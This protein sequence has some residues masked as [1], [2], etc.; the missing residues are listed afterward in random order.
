MRHTANT[1]SSSSSS[2][3]QI[4]PFILR[5]TIFNTGEL[6]GTRVKLF[7]HLHTDDKSNGPGTKQNILTAAGLEPA[8]FRTAALTRRLNHSA[9]LPLHSW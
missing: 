4:K 8:P 7:N 3:P 9:K 2:D 5:H 1:V 6:L